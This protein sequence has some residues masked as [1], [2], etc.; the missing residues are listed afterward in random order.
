MVRRV[1][2]ISAL[3]GV[4][5]VAVLSA[6][7]AGAATNLGE[8]FDPP[9]FCATD[10]TYLVTGSVGNTYT[11]PFDGVIS[12]WSFQTGSFAPESIRLKIGRVTTGTDLSAP[13]TDLSVAGQSASEVPAESSLNTFSTQVSVQQGDFLGIYLG[14]GGGAQCSDSS[15]LGFPDHFNNSEVLAGTSD[16]FD[17]EEEGQIN[18]AAVLEP[19]TDHDGF[20]DETQDACPSN[21]TTQDVCPSPPVQPQT[22]KKKKKCKKHKK[23]HR[24]AESAKKKK[25]KKKKK[26]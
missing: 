3:A 26:R 4:S 23:K 24:S 21:A 18:L 13:S 8:T 25:C 16:S 19:D 20:G 10:T 6:P 1:R 12:G 5:A 22:V 9:S 7:S 17:R 14:P 2:T 15:R 11:V